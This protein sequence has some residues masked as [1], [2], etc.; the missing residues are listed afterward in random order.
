MTVNG[1]LTRTPSA[2]A[3]WPGAQATGPAVLADKV[4]RH[5]SRFSADRQHQKKV[6][7]MEGEKTLFQRAAARHTLK[8]RETCRGAAPRHRKGAQKNLLRRKIHSK[9]ISEIQGFRQD[10]VLEDQGIMTKTQNVVDKVRS[11]HQTESIVAD[12][13]KKGNFLTSSA[14]NQNVQ[15]E[16][17]EILTCVSWERC[18][19]PFNFKRA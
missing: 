6:V 19:K 8:N 12:L 5:C 16:T 18:P 2:G 1:S 11:D 10:A 14:K 9:L 3:T 7:S 17:R 13:G 4:S 15:M